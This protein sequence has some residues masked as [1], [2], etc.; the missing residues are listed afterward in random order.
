ML[1]S[2]TPL[3]AP[4]GSQLSP[5]SALMLENQINE[6]YKDLVNCENISFSWKQRE[7]SGQNDAVMRFLK[8]DYIFSKMLVA[9]NL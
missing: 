1:H 4:A 6:F 9:N 3:P 2:A 7:G 8:L 5:K